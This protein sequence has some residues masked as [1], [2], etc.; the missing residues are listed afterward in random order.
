MYFRIF[1]SLE[2]WLAAA[3]VQETALLQPQAAA[4]PRHIFVPPAALDA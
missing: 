4:I 1:R 3:T 2:P